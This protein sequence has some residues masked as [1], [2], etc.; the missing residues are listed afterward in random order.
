VSAPPAEPGPAPKPPVK[1]RARRVAAVLIVAYL[2]TMGLLAALERSM[3]F[4]APTLPDGWL[5]AE[6]QAQGAR[7]LQPV[8]EDGTRLYGWH[9]PAP[10]SRG[11]VVWFE[12]NGGSVGMR[13]GAF[14]RLSD[15]GWDV[16]QVNYRGY[17]G[18]DGTPNEDGLRMDARAAWAVAKG[19]GG[20]VWIY[21]KS[22]GG[23]VAIGLAAE[24]CDAGD[25]PLALV[26]ESTFASA[27][28]VGQESLPWAPVGLVMRNRFDSLARAPRVTAP[29]L[30]LHGDAD[31]LIGPRHAEDLA[32]ALPNARSE[33]F[34]GAGHNDELLTTGRG[35]AALTA[36]LAEAT[37]GRA[38]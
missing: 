24:V 36:L 30:V 4:P 12:G 19:L 9:L 35:W 29:A 7:E 8:A 23:G 3:L 33:R 25:A 38:R 14:R 27:V 6:A 5:A 32:A 17:P 13:P 28:R 21:G 34:A 31:E 26:V 2:L 16:V 20:P 18:S 15:A 11:V 22:L 37:A 10:A 1:N